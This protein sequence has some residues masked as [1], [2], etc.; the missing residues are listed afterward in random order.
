MKKPS[1]FIQN[2]NKLFR[3]LAN[4]HT[5]ARKLLP[6]S[7]TIYVSERTLASHRVVEKEPQQ[8][9]TK[10]CSRHRVRVLC[11]YILEHSH[12]KLGGWS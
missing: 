3:L 7:D 10:N 5:Q 2:I 11:R 9:N 12:Y 1:S 6:S 4:F 8:Q